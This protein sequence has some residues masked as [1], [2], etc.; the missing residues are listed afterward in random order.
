MQQCQRHQQDGSSN[1]STRL[2]E[3]SDIRRNV[4]TR[5]F[6]KQLLYLVHCEAAAAGND[7]VIGRKTVTTLGR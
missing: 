7:I 6:F 4:K 1:A 2:V 5:N 3:R